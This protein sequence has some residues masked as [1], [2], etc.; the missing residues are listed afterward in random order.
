[1]PRIDTQTRR[2]SADV[3]RITTHLR[4]HGHGDKERQ[5]ERVRH[6]A[7]FRQRH[8]KTLRQQ[9]SASVSRLRSGGDECGTGRQMHQSQAAQTRPCERPSTKHRDSVCDAAAEVPVCASVCADT[10]HHVT[11]QS[12]INVLHMV[13]TLEPRNQ[14]RSRLLT[15]CVPT[16]N[17]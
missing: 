1:M 10:M 2:T 16:K 15:W 9:N 11:Q 5:R 6:H 12:G 17:V 13:T 4:E 8:M 7:K 3:H 14:K